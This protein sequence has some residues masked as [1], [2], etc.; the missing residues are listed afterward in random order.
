MLKTIWRIVLVVL[1]IGLPVFIY[2]GYI[3]KEPVFEAH[4]DVDLGRQTVAAISEDTVEYPI[5]PKADYPEAYAYLQA[6]ADELVSGPEVQYR[7]LFKY[8]S[9]LIIN[10]DDVLNAFCTPGGYIYVYSGLIKYLDA[11]D[12]LD[13]PESKTISF[14]PL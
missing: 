6:M 14:T 11:K 2:L 13:L 1:A 3:A 8:D 10:R 12:Y 7:D 5:L 9:V 4:Y